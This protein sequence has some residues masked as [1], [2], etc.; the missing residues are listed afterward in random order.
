[1]WENKYE[2]VQEANKLANNLNELVEETGELVEE[3]EKISF[4]MWIEL[5]GI[6]AR[7]NRVLT[8]A[9]AR[10]ERRQ[11]ALELANAQQ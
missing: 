10:C 6:E 3:Y 8:K 2:L 7:I 1:M 4:D 11:K 9:L 5:L